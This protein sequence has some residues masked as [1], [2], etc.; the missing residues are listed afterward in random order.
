MFHSGCV[1]DKV[2]Q[3]FLF[4]ASHRGKILQGRAI[5][6]F[7]EFS[8]KDQLIRTV[9]HLTEVQIIKFQFS[10]TKFHVTPPLWT[11]RHHGNI[12]LKNRFS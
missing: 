6:Q 4:M 10:F 7:E 5:A 2:A 9:G 8:S 3:L 1:P 12:G 11:R